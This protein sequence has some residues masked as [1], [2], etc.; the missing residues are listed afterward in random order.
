MIRFVEKKTVITVDWS[1]GKENITFRNDSKWYF[2]VDDEEATREDILKQLNSQDKKKFDS[3]I[4]EYDGSSKDGIGGTLEFVVGGASKKLQYAIE[5]VLEPYLI[6]DIK[7][8]LKSSDF[9]DFRD[10]Y[11]DFELLISRSSQKVKDV[12]YGVYEDIP[13]LS[14]FKNYLRDIAKV[15]NGKLKIVATKLLSFF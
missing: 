12:A 13:T 10:L 7:K 3:L 2:T 6:D 9:S 14:Y 1:Y 5:D 4:R 15:G 11:N 8:A